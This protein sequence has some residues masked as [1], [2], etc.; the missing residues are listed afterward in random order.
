MI[1]GATYN[2][3]FVEFEKAEEGATKLRVLDK[4]P[5]FGNIPINREYTFFNTSLGAIRSSFKMLTDIGYKGLDDDYIALIAK[6]KRNSLYGEFG[7]VIFPKW[8]ALVPLKFIKK[9]LSFG[10]SMQLYNKF[11][12]FK[13]L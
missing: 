13:S 8:K 1:Y 6:E 10:F 7:M 5:V 3:S 9:S 12:N 4:V 11:P 2:N